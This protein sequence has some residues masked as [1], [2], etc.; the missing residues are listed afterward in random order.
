MYTCHESM[1]SIFTIALF[2]IFIGF[3][4][5]GQSNI[6]QDLKNFNEFLGKE[7]SAALDK[8]IESYEKFLKVNYPNEKDQTA[9]AKKF[10]TEL[11]DLNYWD[12]NRWSFDTESNKKILEEW[13][14]N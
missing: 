14:V 1:K 12:M 13:E 10:L 4:S 8:A 2:S 3:P 5:Y 7:R 9:R 6:N 11:R